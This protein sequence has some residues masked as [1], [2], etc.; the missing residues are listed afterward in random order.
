MANSGLASRNRRSVGYI[1]P[2][3]TKN[4]L[5]SIPLNSSIAWF[6][7]AKVWGSAESG[8]LGCRLKEN[9]SKAVFLSEFF[10]QK[11]WAYKVDF[12]DIEYRNSQLP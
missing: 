12:G 4:R 8:G 7:I 11:G 3:Y 2:R 9:L 10:F 6:S 5:R 1:I